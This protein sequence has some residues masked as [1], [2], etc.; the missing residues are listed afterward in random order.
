MH[1]HRAVILYQDWQEIDSFDIEKMDVPSSQF[2]RGSLS[3]SLW[4][5]KAKNQLKKACLFPSYWFFMLH[6][7]LTSFRMGPYSEERKAGGKLK[8]L[9]PADSVF[10]CV[11]QP[12]SA[13]S[14]L[15]WA[16]QLVLIVC[17]ATGPTRPSCPWGYFW[18]LPTPWRSRWERRVLTLRDSARTAVWEET[19]K[20]FLCSGH[21]LHPF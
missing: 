6:M 16:W 9:T 8:A 3:M 4:Y 21:P 14:W 5:W 7:L 15:L 1:T 12:T 2:L 11:L 13:S 17:G 10:A 20:H 19:Q 18:L